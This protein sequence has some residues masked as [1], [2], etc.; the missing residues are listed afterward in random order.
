MAYRAVRTNTWAPDVRLS[1]VAPERSCRE[2]T[3]NASIQRNMNDLFFVW[4]WST[5]GAGAV[6][7]EHLVSFV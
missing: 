3:I 1:G 6:S 4:E 5:V 7:I 2:L